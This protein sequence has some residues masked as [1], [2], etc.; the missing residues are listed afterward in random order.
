MSVEVQQLTKIY[1]QQVAVNAISFQLEKGE[2]T[3]F[4][5]PNGAGE[6]GLYRHR[7]ADRRQ[8]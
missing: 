4:L 5:G 6:I 1:G 7:T 3:G 8:A 2:I